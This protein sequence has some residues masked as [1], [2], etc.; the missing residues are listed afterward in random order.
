[1]PDGICNP[2][3]TV[4]CLDG[5]LGHAQ[6]VSDGFTKPVARTS[7]PVALRFRRR[8]R[9][10]H[11]QH[12][13]SRFARTSANP[14]TLRFTKPVAHILHNEPDGICNPVRNILCHGEYAD[15][16]HDMPSWMANIPHNKTAPLHKTS[17]S[18]FAIPTRSSANPVT[19]RIIP[20]R[21]SQMPR[22]ARFAGIPRRASTLRSCLDAYACISGTNNRNRKVERNFASPI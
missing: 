17:G 12:T 18:G 20:R 3:R 13:P 6:N 9:V 7:Y 16:L 5:V 22:R 19:L 11:I 1:M 21:A 10:A 14:V 4:L 8:R 2:V 15:G